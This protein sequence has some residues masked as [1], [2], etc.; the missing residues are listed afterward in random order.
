MG[1]AKRGGKGGGAAGPHFTPTTDAARR[2]RAAKLA[3]ALRTNLGRRKA[4]LAQRQEGADSG[5]GEEE[6]P[7]RR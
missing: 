7:P 1:K 2:A 5:E 4:D 6:D 3:A